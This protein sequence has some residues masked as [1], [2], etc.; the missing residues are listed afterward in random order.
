M[1]KASDL[2]L[3]C[4]RWPGSALIITAEETTR[5]KVTNCSS[6]SLAMKPNRAATPLRVA[7]GLVA[8]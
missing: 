6:H 2:A 8:H 7:K 1:R 4:R 3:C 5:G